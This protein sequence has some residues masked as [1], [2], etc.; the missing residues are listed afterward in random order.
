M[1]TKSLLYF[2]WVLCLLGGA[3]C[4]SHSGHSSADAGNGAM[5]KPSGQAG[6]NK[7]VT[8]ALDTLPVWLAPEAP[9][10]ALPTGPG[11]YASLE[12]LE[13]LSDTALTLAASGNADAAQ[14]HLFTLQDQVAMPLPAAA[15]AD[16]VAH[17]RSLERRVWLIGGLLA[18]KTAERARLQA[19]R[20]RLA[21]L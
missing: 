21:E 20:A 2:F 18:E 19:A 11:G 7:Q 5:P 17:R 15:D 10:V 16:Y 13:A 3:G 8:A 4:A 1:T 9:L 12:D 6:P 14:D